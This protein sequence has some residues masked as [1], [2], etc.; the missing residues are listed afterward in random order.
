M[1]GKIYT[2]KIMLENCPICQT[3]LIEKRSSGLDNG[4]DCPQ[5]GKF[6]MQYHTKALLPSLD[7]EKTAVISHA[8]RKRQKPCRL[9]HQGE[10]DVL[11]QLICI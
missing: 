7:E 8:I 1:S 5:C 10:N 4:Y 2:E 11:L 9:M 6:V 3:E